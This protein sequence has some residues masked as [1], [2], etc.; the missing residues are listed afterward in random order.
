MLVIDE[1]CG[2]VLAG[3][4]TEQEL[5]LDLLPKRSA[6]L[7]LGQVVR[8]V[9]GDNFVQQPELENVELHGND[10]HPE[11]FSLYH[12]QTQAQRLTVKRRWP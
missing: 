7:L 10:F 8:L 1:K 4:G 2:L 6:I 12:V 11:Q 3:I 9:V 5:F